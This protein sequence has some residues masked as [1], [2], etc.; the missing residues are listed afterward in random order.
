MTIHNKNRVAE[1]WHTVALVATLALSPTLVAFAAPPP[2]NPEQQGL[3][4]IRWE[5]IQKQRTHARPDVAPRKADQILPSAIRKIELHQPTAL[6]SKEIESFLHP[7]I[8][9]SHLSD[10]AL[11]QA[12]GQIWDFYRE[13]GR[14]VRVE[15][16]AIPRAD[17]GGGSILKAQ[18]DEVSVRNVLVEQEGGHSLKQSL[19]DN[20]LASTKDDIANGGVLDLDRL[21]SRLKK[22][23]FLKDVGVRASLVPIDPEHVDVKVLVSPAE[24][25]PLGFLAQYDN[26]GMRTYGRD[27]YIAGITV[28]GR[29]LAG[30]KFDLLGLFSSGM[31]YGR[32]SYEFPLIS[33]G[34]RVNVWGSHINYRVS[35]VSDGNTT[36]LGTGLRYPLYI[37]NSSTW[38][39]A[40]NYVNVRQV[41][42]LADGTPTDKKITHS[43]EGKLD[44]SYLLS[45]SQ[46]LF[47]NASVTLGDLDLSSLPSSQEQDSL[48]SKT[49]GHFSKLEL[50]GG[51]SA[52]FGPDSKL[53]SRLE[54]R[55]QLANKN[56]DGS[57]KFTLGGPLG[58]SSY[59][60]SEGQGDEGYVGNAEIG[61]RPSDKWRIFTFYDIGRIRQNKHPW[62]VQ[63]TPLIY[64]LQGAGVGFT[65]TLQSVVGSATYSRQIGSNPG[66]SAAGLDSDGLNDRYR[67]WLSLAWRM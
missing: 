46:S 14:L 49:G 39:G 3:P 2:P 8:G 36:M 67:L 58:V 15:L 34:A 4:A 12:R 19:L 45:P 51:W 13:Q 6:F 23:L 33:M 37:G 61:Y 62:S 60:P 66:L 26:E 21:N 22:R 50:G 25:Q 9:K 48:T 57:E 20:I 24:V 40:L 43:I 1:P 41:D 5:A 30:D 47:A 10:S 35:S 53:D 32:M 65:Y 64:T 17:V 16:T 42:N 28:P 27:R 18:I 7:F 44:T 11:E 56:L 59:G 54:I 63:T 38:E 31:S 29:L 55:G 52:L